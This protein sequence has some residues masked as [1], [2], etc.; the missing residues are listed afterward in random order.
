MAAVDLELEE[1]P[2]DFVGAVV[3]VM[4][5]LR[6]FDADNPK[7]TLSEVSKQTGLDRAGA[8][9]YL[10]TLAHLGYVVQEG[11]DFR[12]SPKVLELGYAFMATMPISDIAQSYL[13]KIT[14][15]TGESAAI[16]I[17]DEDHIVHLARA[18]VNRMFA[19]IIHVGGRFPALYTSTGRVMVAF[20]PDAELDAF[21]KRADL[22]RN[23]TWG[24]TKKTQLRAELMKIRKQGYAIADQEIEEGVRS[25]AVP[26]LGGDNKV[27]AALIVLTNVATVPK[28]K[29]TDEFLPILLESAKELQ[30]ALRH[31]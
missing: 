4:N 14:E 3:H 17:L 19:P 13:N 1:R 7:M 21:V 18:N 27:L 26:I 28:K 5:V 20:K 12:L 29:L 6:A 10:L 22:L 9:R 23:S 30:T 24:V 16:A 11:K 25:I 8:R 15:L 31:A 2:R